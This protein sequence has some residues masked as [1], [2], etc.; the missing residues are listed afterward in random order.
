MAIG[1]LEAALMETWTLFA[2]GSIAIILRIFSRT[3]LVGIAGWC[4]D[5]YLIFFGWVRC[6]MY[7]E[8]IAYTDIYSLR[9]AIPA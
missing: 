1:P 9:H 7:L 6:S 5:D 4:P 3:R 8:M 2:I